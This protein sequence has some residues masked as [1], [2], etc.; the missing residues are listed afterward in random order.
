[1]SPH[2]RRFRE[3]DL[4]LTTAAALALALT[5]C[6]GDDD[7][8]AASAS[9]SPTPTAST[10]SEA[11]TELP[12]AGTVDTADGGKI[13]YS[14]RGSGEPAMLLEAGSDS[15]GS[16]ELMFTILEPLGEHTKVCTY[17]R[18][19]T[20]QSL[21][22]PAHR[23]TL[24]DACAVQ[25]QVADALE[26]APYV[27]F[28]TSGG[29]NIAIGCARRHPERIAG[30]VLAEAYHDSPQMM[31]AF[32]RKEGWTWRSN[33]E[34]LDWIAITDELDQMEMPIG[35]FPVLV[36]SASDADKGN[37]ENQAYW[38]D[39]SPT[40]RQQVIKG[41]HGLDYDNR[42]AVVRE[43]LDLLEAVRT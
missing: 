41:G 30:L 4:L 16:E 18:P 27:L 34:H 26:L 14:C 32:Q 20:G 43:M 29:G 37:D 21:A 8:E 7:P 19:G 28:G 10:A 2:P 15:A 11:P 5:A 38:L 35:E 40:S 42:D 23:R 36:L 17:D 25:D 13:F 3:R 33:V 31:R 6:A 12:P 24:D 1:M 39:L 22:P 9:T